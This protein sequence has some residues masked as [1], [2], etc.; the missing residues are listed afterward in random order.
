MTNRLWKFFTSLRLTVVLLVLC[1]V[2]VFLGTIA[3]V[4]EGLWQAQERWFK[5]FLVFRRADDAWWVPPVFLGGYTLG[6]G[7]LI[8]LIAA[9]LKR[10]QLSWK[11]VGI[12]ITHFGVILLLAGQLITDLFSRESFMSFAEGETRSFSEAHREVEL[13]VNTTPPGDSGKDRVIAFTQAALAKRQPLLNAELPFEIRINEYGENG[14]VLTHDGIRE[15]GTRLTTALATLETNYSSADG[16]VAQAVK[17]AESQGRLVIWQEVLKTYGENDKDIVAAAKRVAADPKRE[18]PFREDLKRRFR[19]QMLEAFQ[20]MP[21]MQ[22][23]N[24]QGRGMSY[25]ARETVAGR[26]L[27]LDALETSA[28][29]GA[30]LKMLLVPKPAVR[31]MDEQNMPYAKV[32]L[33]HKGTSLGS[34]LLSGWL[35]PQEFTVDGRVYRFAIRNE[36][37]FQPFSLS[38]VKTTHEVYTGTE[39]PK[40]F[41]SRVRLENP[42]TQEKREIDISMNNPLRYGGLT[43]YQSQMGRTEMTG[44]KGTSVLQVVRNP[45]W[46]TPYLGCV[47]VSVGMLW[48]FLYHLVGFLSKPRIASGSQTAAARS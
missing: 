10:F 13:V 22:S 4:H 41:Q 42:E 29:Q 5:S 19:A 37:Y 14:E 16:I 35:N 2:L 20:K 26:P 34:W 39:I 25:V 18:G 47:L 21:R 1:T 17:G 12:H 33:F 45:G 30:G 23:A 6:F 3:Q 31:G 38:L 9:H 8:N 44:G 46:L 15:A 36:R 32:E 11:K 24:E 28:N 27:K 43:F 7:L 40:N 48:Q